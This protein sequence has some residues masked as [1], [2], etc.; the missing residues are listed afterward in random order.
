M[1]NELESTT[2][3]T[4]EAETTKP[5]VPHPSWVRLH[6]SNIRNLDELAKFF[7]DLDLIR[8]DLE[9]KPGLTK[10]QAIVRTFAWIFFALAAV[11]LGTFVLGGAVTLSD[12]WLDAS[13]GVF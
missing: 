6:R 1:S 8:E 7:R 11:F 4:G 2:D 13:G 10:A 9:E 12:Y 5:R 3:E